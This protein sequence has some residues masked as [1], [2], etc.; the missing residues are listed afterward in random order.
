LPLL[1]ANSAFGRRLLAFG[2]LRPA[3]CADEMGH[4]TFS[5]EKRAR[6]V[7][8]ATTH[9]SSQGPPSPPRPLTSVKFHLGDTT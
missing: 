2:I 7:A 5:T 6:T 4:E 1:L 3:C 8:K 9:R